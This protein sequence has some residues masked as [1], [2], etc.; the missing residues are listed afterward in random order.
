MAAGY[1]VTWHD[2]VAEIRLECGKG[3]ALNPRSH[4]RRRRRSTRRPATSVRSPE[5]WY[6]RAAIPSGLTVQVAPGAATRTVQAHSRM[7]RVR[8]AAS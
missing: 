6:G 2:G 3:N 5:A 1:A 8:R 7:I 4:A